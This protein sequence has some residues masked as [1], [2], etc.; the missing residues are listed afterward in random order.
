MEVRDHRSGHVKERTLRV[1]STG[2]AENARL[3]NFTMAV[4]LQASGQVANALAPYEQADLY[5]AFQLRLLQTHAFKA[6]DYT[7]RTPKM[8]CGHLEYGA[9]RSLQSFTCVWSKPVTA[10]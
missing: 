10:M 9:E 6:F 1:L 2:D 4:H 3:V 5:R 8:A 7:N